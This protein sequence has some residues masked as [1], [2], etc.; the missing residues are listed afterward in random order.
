[1]GLWI[2]TA[3]QS[4][5]RMGQQVCCD[6]VST[7][8]TRERFFVVLVSGSRGGAEGR[9]EA[10]ALADGAASML[11]QEMPPGAVAEATLATLPHDKHV[12]LS[13][14][15]VIGGGEASVVEC[16]APPL[17]LVHEKHLILLP[18]LEEELHGRLFREGQFH[19]HDGDHMAML[20]EGY[21]YPR[22]WGWQGIAHAVRRW[23][24][25]QCDA[26]EL[27]GA[28]VRTYQ[29]LNP[30]P[31]SQDVTVV[32]MHAR[33]MR[34]ATIWVG[35]PADPAQDEAVLHELM[36]EP[37]VRVL[38]GGTTAQIAARLLGT[39]L[40][41][42]PRPVGGWEEVPPTA[43]MESVSLVTEGLVTLRRVRERIAGDEKPGSGPRFGLEDVRADGATR[44]ARMLPAMDRIRFLVGM[45]VNPQQVDEAGVPLRREVVEGLMRELEARGKIV[46][47]KYL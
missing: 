20:S 12:P 35:P 24:D 44:L 38:C 28:L 45:A 33:P 19:L 1:M 16:D 46:S 39:E 40:R 29:R 43:Q 25:T 37:G 8:R 15:Q 47:V 9:T 21:L 32:A 5:L 42:E 13:I 23:T 17:F 4:L 14:L 26:D 27:L 34:S 31:P 41:M 22:R 6:V 10:E 30:E 2:E 36:G 11:R 7:F 3:Y 18:V